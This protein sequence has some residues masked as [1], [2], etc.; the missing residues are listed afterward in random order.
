MKSCVRKGFVGKSLARKTVARV[1]RE[2]ALEDRKGLLA[3]AELQ[4]GLGQV[5]ERDGAAR[6]Q[7]APFFSAASRSVA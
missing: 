6:P 5:P 3:F 2:G 1:E 4:R 7:A